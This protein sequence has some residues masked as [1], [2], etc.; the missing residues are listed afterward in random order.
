MPSLSKHETAAPAAGKIKT[1]AAKPDTSA[2][3]PPRAITA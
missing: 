1:K 2:F 3:L